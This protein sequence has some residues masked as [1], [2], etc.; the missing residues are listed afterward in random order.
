MEKKKETFLLYSFQNHGKLR[1]EL[2]LPNVTVNDSTTRKTKETSGP[3]RLVYFQ[4]AEFS[5]AQASPS[6]V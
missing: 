3:K 1:K 6:K 5:K 4:D 2:T